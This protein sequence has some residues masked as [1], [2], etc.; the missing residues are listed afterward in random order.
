[1][2]SF[3]LSARTTDDPG[4]HARNAPSLYADPVAWLLCEVTGQALAGCPDDVL[5]HTDEVGHLAVSDHGTLDTMRAL[6]RSGRRGRVSPLRFAG[7]NPGSLAGLACLRW[8]LRGPT[9]MLAM[10]PS[11]AG[12]AA[13]AVAQ[14]WLDTGQARH[15][16]LATH[17][18]RDGVHEARCA[19]LARD[20]VAGTTPLD[21]AD[22]AGGAPVT[23]R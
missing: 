16:V 3:G 11:P 9:M 7:A 8:G 12:P 23:V 10:P 20:A 19:V 21:W 6:A 13:V 2:H 14:R 5:H 18:V 17:T 4:T 22:V 1:M 15:V